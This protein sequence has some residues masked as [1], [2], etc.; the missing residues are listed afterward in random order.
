MKKSDVL[1]VSTFSL[2]RLKKR[3]QLTLFVIV[4]VVVVISIV[5]Y[6]FMR[7]DL[8]N[9]PI[10]GSD[11]IVAGLVSCVEY[12][13]QNS[14]SIVAY[15]GGYNTPPEKHFS[16]SPTF[17]PYYYYEGESYVPSL[18]MFESEMGEFV[19]ENIRD[20]LDEVEVA[21]FDINYDELDVQVDIS[22]E[23]VEFVIDSPITLSREEMSM[24]IEMKRYPVFIP[25]KL[26]YL[27]EVSEFFVQEQLEDPDYYCLSC[28]LE[29]CNRND[30][31]FYIFPLMEDVYMIMAFEKAQDPLILNFVAKYKPSSN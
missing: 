20:C 10:D 25:S 13:S 31:R 6:F 15:Q 14:L 23:G 28:V 30:I 12:T 5:V 18:E 21:G 4:A 9:K 1:D 11:V 22:P 29:M 24:R 27:H 19:K 26:Y 16:F 17:F 2:L 3:A 7:G 8:T